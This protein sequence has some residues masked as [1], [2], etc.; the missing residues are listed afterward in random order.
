M[1]ATQDGTLQIWD[2]WIPD[3][4]AVGISFARGRLAATDMLLVHAAPQKL[5]VEVV[6]E[7]GVRV[8]RGQNLPRTS[9]T[10]IARLR[11]AGDTVTR[12]D[13]WPSEADYGVPVLLAGGE[14]GRLTAWWNAPD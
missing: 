10:P 9:D 6:D 3:V 1:A 7:R 13:I 14:V 11:R 2:L 8:A 12:A 4:A 5:T